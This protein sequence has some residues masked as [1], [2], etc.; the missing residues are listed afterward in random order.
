MHI[1]VGTLFINLALLPDQSTLGKAV[2]ARE[3]LVRAKYASC[4]PAINT[5][6]VYRC[7]DPRGITNL[8]ELAAAIYGH[9]VQLREAA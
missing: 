2:G 1:S 8:R 7:G 6:T 4:F 3:L 9:K 5:V